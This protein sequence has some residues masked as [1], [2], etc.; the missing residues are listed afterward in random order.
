[1]DIS[2]LSGVSSEYL[3]VY[4]KRADLVEKEDESFASV[5]SSMMDSLNETNALQ[6][7]AEAEEIRFAMGESENTH[8]LLIAESK[9]NIALQYTVAVRDKLIEGYREL[10]QMSV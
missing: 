4:A 1:M 3:N 2:T 8:D 7:R 10:M 5:F 9:A 6:N